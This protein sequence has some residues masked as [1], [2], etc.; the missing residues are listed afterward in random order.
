[1]YA[2]KAEQEPQASAPPFPLYHPP[3]QVAPGFPLPP[4][5]FVS[6]PQQY[7]HPP[8]PQPYPPQGRPLRPT[9]WSTG[10]CA[11]CTD[12]SVCCLTCW[13]PCITFGQIA[14]IV[15]EGSP[16]CCVSGGIYGALLCLTGFAY[17]YSCWYRTKI[18]D[19]YN[20]ADI[21]CADCLVHCFCEPCA[22][23]QEYRELKL[24]GFPPSLGWEG[25]LRR[26][27]QGMGTDM[28]APAYPTMAR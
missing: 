12:Q 7:V 15:D 18:R 25:N 3:Q 8:A 4:Q 20:L 14:E 1:M 28:A 11:C 10:L 19:K 27:Q 23:C 24:Q 17:C 22:L 2:P 26:Q 6:A 9:E 13:C 5:N 16:T 21:P